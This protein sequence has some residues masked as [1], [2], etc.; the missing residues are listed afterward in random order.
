MCAISSEP[1]EL[2]PPALRMPVA[3]GVR[4]ALR[5]DDQM[6]NAIT[7]DVIAAFETA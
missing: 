2:A 1:L 4:I 7:D 5:H 6:P 3:A